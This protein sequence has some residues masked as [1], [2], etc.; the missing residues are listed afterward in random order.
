[1][2][3]IQA[4]LGGPLIHLVGS[5]AFSVRLGTLLIFAL[6]LVSM[7]FLVCLLYTPAYALFIIALLS[8]GSD[9]MMGI[10]L[11]ANGG[12]CL[13]NPFRAP[14]FLFGNWAFPPPPPPKTPPGRIPPLVPLSPGA[15]TPPGPPVRP[16]CLF[17][18]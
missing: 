12:G 15:A 18:C 3:T 4:S 8:I 9:R 2:G 5:S 17:P 7:Y 6:Y 10:P 11:V 1:M 16:P 13:N 14:L